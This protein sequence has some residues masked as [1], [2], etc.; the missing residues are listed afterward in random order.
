MV[1]ELRGSDFEI[2]L[3][4]LRMSR[5][6]R[7]RPVSGPSAKTAQEVNDQRH[8]EDKPKCAAAKQGATNIKATTTEQEE[9]HNE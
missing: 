5:A 7:F 3:P 4:A 6:G 9:E 1:V 8:H 2:L